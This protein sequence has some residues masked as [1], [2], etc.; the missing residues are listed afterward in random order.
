MGVQDFT[1]ADATAGMNP[2]LMASLN[3]QLDEARRQSEIDRVANAG[4]MTKAGAFGGSRQAL[5]DMEGQ[6]GLQ[7]NLADIT[8]RG[9]KDA[10]DVARDQ[11]NKTQT[12]R[13]A[14]G[15]DVLNEQQEA[16]ATERGIE[17][18]GM[19][20]DYA[21]FNEERQFPYTQVQYMKSLLQGLPLEAQTQSYIAPSSAAQLANTANTI[22]ELY[23]EYGP[24]SSTPF[25]EAIYGSA[26]ATQIRAEQVANPS[27]TNAQIKAKYP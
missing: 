2:Y 6:R 14:Y 17:S 10:Y 23:G 13:N 5:M 26:T 21:Q 11:F 27:I 19:A 16:G 25:N 3:P 24:G 15:F 18:E 1:A 7:A 4:R 9:Y 8:G 22:D 12:A 20:A